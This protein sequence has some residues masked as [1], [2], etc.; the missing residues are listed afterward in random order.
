MDAKT[1]AALVEMGIMVLG[2]LYATLM[3]FRKVNAKPGDAKYEAW[4]GRFGRHLKWLG[5]AVMGF[6]VVLF[7]IRKR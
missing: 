4:H 2:G 3:G 6:G 1:V 7:L 5:P